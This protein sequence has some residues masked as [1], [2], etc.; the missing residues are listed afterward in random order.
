MTKFKSK[1]ILPSNTLL[2]IGGVLVYIALGGVGYGI[3]V[4]IIG[5]IS[6][7]RELKLQNPNRMWAKILSGFYIVF[8]YICYFLFSVNFL[9]SMLDNLY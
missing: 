2:Y 7:K 6:L 3:V 5:I 1:K 8:G 9:I 4:G